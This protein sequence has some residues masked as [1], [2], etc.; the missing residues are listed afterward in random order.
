M[1]H[2][3]S[4]KASGNGQHTVTENSPWASDDVTVTNRFGRRSGLQIVQPTG[5][6]VVT[7]AWDAAGRWSVVDV[8]F[9]A[10]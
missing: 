8:S 6:F 2:F 10:A 5:A 9:P 7:N 1:N 4:A 3:S